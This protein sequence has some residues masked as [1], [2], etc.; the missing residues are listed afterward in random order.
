MKDLP[1]RMLDYRAKN[2]MSQRE[3]AE[4]VKVTIQTINSVERGLQEPSRLTRKKIEL[5]IGEE[6]ET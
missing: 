4:K 6:R 5:V 1:E 2:N 3:L